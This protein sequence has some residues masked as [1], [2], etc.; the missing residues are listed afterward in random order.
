MLVYKQ[1]NIKNIYIYIQNLYKQIKGKGKGSVFLFRKIHSW[2]LLSTVLIHVLKLKETSLNSIRNISK[3]ILLGN[4][5]EKYHYEG[6]DT[7]NRGFDSSL[8]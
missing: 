2:N 6:A 5:S 3:Q 4:S 1:L 7:C 8:E